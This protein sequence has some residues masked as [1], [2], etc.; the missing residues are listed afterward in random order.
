MPLQRTVVC[1]N[2][3]TSV[4]LWE[5]GTVRGGPDQGDVGEAWPAPQ[6]DVRGEQARLAT[7]NERGQDLP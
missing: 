1:L 2:L 3:G 4:C 5:G 7:V 6:E